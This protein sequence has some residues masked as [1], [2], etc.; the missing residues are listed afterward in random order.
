MVG[1]GGF[2]TCNLSVCLEHFEVF[3]DRGAV[4]MCYLLF[5]NFIPV[6]VPL[7]G[8]EA[9]EKGQAARNATPPPFSVRGGPLAHTATG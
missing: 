4:S 9:V 1:E 7:D 8:S 5:I 6:M 3:R 2:P